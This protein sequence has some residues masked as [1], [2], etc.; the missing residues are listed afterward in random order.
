MKFTIESENALYATAERMLRAFP[1]G[2]VFCFFG[3]MGVG[4]TTFIKEICRYLGAV[5]TTS[6]PTFSIVNEYVTQ[7][8]ESIYHFD[9]Y[10]IETTQ[11]A[12]EMGIED[13]LYSGNYC[14][15]EWSERISAFIQPEFIKVYMTMDDEG[16][17]HINIG[18]DE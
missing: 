5:D 18:C 16:A 2:R 11:D 14:F 15:I 6:S 12:Y 7:N 9:F 13:Y 17:R 8:D 3:E 4:K 10:R 1:E